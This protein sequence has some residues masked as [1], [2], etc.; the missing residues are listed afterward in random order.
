MRIVKAPKGEEDRDRIAALIAELHK[1]HLSKRRTDNTVKRDLDR[2]VVSVWGDRDV[3]SI[4]RLDVVGLLDGI[5][6]VG[7]GV[8]AKQGAG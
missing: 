1:R 5:A 7:H 2:H 4:S 8:A 6:E 3:K